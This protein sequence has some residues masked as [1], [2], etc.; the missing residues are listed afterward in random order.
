MTDIPEIKA[1]CLQNQHLNVSIDVLAEFIGELKPGLIIPSPLSI[2]N[3]ECKNE[4][5]HIRAAKRRVNAAYAAYQFDMAKVMVRQA[6]QQLCEYG[7]AAAE[8]QGIAEIS[9]H[10]STADDGDDE[11]PKKK[12]RT[13]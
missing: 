8:K 11:R 10:P 3:K 12:Q 2:D 6:L 9:P 7:N 5:P 4:A 13:D 1:L